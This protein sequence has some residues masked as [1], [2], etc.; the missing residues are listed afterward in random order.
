MIIALV[1]LSLAG[2]KNETPDTSHGKLKCL[3]PVKVNPKL[4]QD[5]NTDRTEKCLAV[6][7]KS[8]PVKK[9]QK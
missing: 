5:V 2:V 9:I 6:P 7:D 3:N 4:E 8:K 1:V